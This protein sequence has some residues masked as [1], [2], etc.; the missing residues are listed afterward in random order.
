MLS[1]DMVRAFLARSPAPL[2]YATRLLY[3]EVDSYGLD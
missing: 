2:Y 3:I 1:T